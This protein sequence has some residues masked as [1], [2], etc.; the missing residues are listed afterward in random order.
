MRTFD[1]V[2]IEYPSAGATYSRPVYGVYGYDT[3]PDTSVLS[4]QERRT[5]LDTFETLEEAQTQHPEAEWQ[6]LGS[7]YREPYLDH[8]PD[9]PDGPGV[10]DPPPTALAI[11]RHE[12]LDLAVRYQETDGEAAALASLIWGVLDREDA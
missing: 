11:L 12:A 3:Y 4:G 8:L 1:Y 6:K 5:F 9:G 10:L 2:L 7:Q